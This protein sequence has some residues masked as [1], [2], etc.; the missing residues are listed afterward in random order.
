[1]YQ[2]DQA[3]RHQPCG[4]Y[5]DEQDEDD[6]PVR[7]VQDHCAFCDEMETRQAALAKEKRDPES[8]G[9]HGVFLRWERTEVD[10]E[11][12]DDEDGDNH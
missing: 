6:L 9:A 1:M 3:A 7:L 2:A 10:P 11:A 5:L 4:H 8:T 12:E